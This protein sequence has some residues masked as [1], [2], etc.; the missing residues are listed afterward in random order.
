MITIDQEL[1]DFLKQEG[2]YE[3]FLE[4]V[5]QDINWREVDEIRSIDNIGEAFTWRETERK[6]EGYDYWKNINNKWC[7]YKEENEIE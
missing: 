2:V 3:S 5:E 6:G 4:N 1:K 7:N